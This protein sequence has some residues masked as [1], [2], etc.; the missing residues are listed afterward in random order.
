ML[1]DDQKQEIMRLSSLLATARV[2]RARFNAG[3]YEVPGTTQ[4]S[5]N[6]RVQ[7]AEQALSDYL[8]SIK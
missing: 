1:T 7:R 2:I 3:T 4:E 8:D 6:A 5:V